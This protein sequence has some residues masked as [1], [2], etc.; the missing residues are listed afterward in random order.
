MTE[1]EYNS[2]VADLNESHCDAFD[3]VVQ[4]T[5]ARHQ[6]YMGERESIP[7]P[8]HI[9]ITGGAGKSHLIS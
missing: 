2:K 8:L 3:R 9:F 4:Y 7:E 5:C 6:Y 1:A